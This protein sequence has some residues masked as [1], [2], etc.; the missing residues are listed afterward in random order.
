M[1]VE[2]ALGGLPGMV[3][4]AAA[5]DQNRLVVRY[6]TSQWNYRKLVL[7]VLMSGPATE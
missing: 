4:P 2:R 6:N 5:A 1:T 3:K 7:L